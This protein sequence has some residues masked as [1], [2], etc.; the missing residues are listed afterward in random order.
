MSQFLRWSAVLFGCAYLANAQAVEMTLSSNAP[1][2]PQGQIKDAIVPNLPT[3]ISQLGSDYQLFA[4]VETGD[5]LPGQRLYSY[6]V[7]L[8]RKVIESGTGKTYWV[9]TGGIRGHGVAQESETV[10]S[11]L[12][13]DVIAGAKAG[14]FKLDQM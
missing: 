1:D 12:K 11:N 10:L 6:S 3:A 9:P 8:H 4:I 13:A 14:S 7:T 2:V 5:Y